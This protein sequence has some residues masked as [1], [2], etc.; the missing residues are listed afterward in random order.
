MSKTAVNILEGAKIGSGA[1]II[2]GNV[3]A[4][5]IVCS[6]ALDESS[7]KV[8]KKPLEQD[9]QQITIIGGSTTTIGTTFE[10]VGGRTFQLNNISVERYDIDHNTYYWGVN[11]LVF[12]PNTI[13]YNSSDID[14]NMILDKEINQIEW[15][16]L[17][18]RLDQYKKK[19]FLMNSIP[20]WLKK[21]PT[22]DSPIEELVVQFK[23]QYPKSNYSDSLLM[24]VFTEVMK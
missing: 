5:P 21:Q 1:T 24:M 22:I 10:T 11:S 23:T 18:N 19:K 8:H 12:G 14:L 6:Y 7:Q 17:I 15:N 9:Q 16:E 13:R 4:A 2:I 3:V 20:G